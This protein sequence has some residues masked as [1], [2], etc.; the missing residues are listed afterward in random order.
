MGHVGDEWCER[1]T[2]VWF[3]GCRK[4]AHTA[5]MKTTQHGDNASTSCGEAGEFQ[6]TF[7]GFSAAVTEKDRIEPFGGEMGKP[8]KQASTYII[9]EDFRAGNE[10]LGLEY[11]CGSNL[12]STVTDICHSMPCGAVDILATFG[13]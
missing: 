4:S 5:T 11:K 10:A 12:R 6:R 3:P 13:I 9:V 7:N 8:F 2:I 1:L